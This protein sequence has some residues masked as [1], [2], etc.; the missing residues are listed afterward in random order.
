[1]R[2]QRFVSGDLFPG[3]AVGPIAPPPYSYFE[4]LAV[5][6]IPWYPWLHAFLGGPVYSRQHSVISFIIVQSDYHREIAKQNQYVIIKPSPGVDECISVAGPTKGVDRSVLRRLERENLKRD[7]VLTEKFYSY[8]A[9]A[10]IQLHGLL[11][12]VRLDLEAHQ[13]VPNMH[14]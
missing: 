1:M 10:K 13:C 8:V 11:P 7:L 2:S 14:W 4:I 5:D 6:L 3:I 9:V 12:E